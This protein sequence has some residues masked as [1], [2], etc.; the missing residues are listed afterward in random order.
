LADLPL[1]TAQRRFS[2]AP[3]ISTPIAQI[4][5]TECAFRPFFLLVATWIPCSVR[6]MGAD[7][8]DRGKHSLDE[9]INWWNS[10]GAGTRNEATTRLHLIDGLL[11]GV[12]CWPKGDIT[13]EQSHGGTFTDYE[14][15]KPATRV[16]VEAKK[17]G[18]YFELPAGVGPGTIAIP[19]VADNSDD[20]KDAIQQVLRYCQDRGVA[21]A[22][23][24]NGH[25]IL[26]F[27]ASRQDG[28][29]PLTGRALV[30]DS[31]E[32]VRSSFQ[33]AWDNLSQRSQGWHNQQRRFSPLG[34][35][36]AQ[37]TTGEL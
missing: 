29:P 34:S 21:L 1:K 24:T 30:F 2:R 36:R 5:D 16:I 6:V 35:F 31:L 22:V 28:V 12:L 9:L 7:D 17:E 19:S 3:P 25:Q 18:I 23:V 8:Y 11:T 15:G 37:R 26:A 20:I 27:V 10:E 4:E 13:A 32:A 33:L 14:L